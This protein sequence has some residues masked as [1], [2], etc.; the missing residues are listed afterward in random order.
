MPG[1]LFRILFCWFSVAVV[2]FGSELKPDE[3]VV[4]FPTIGQ[5]VKDGWDLEIHGVV[6]ELSN[7]K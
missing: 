6:Y 3:T 2:A 1:Q 7:H 4:F 5:R